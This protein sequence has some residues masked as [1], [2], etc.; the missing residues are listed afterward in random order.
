MR[1]P[2]L[3]NSLC[4][5]SIQARSKI[6]DVLKNNFACN[7]TGDIRPLGSKYDT[8]NLSIF[9][10]GAGKLNPFMPKRLKSNNTSSVS[11]P[12]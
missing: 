6:A 1:R 2:I 4:Y 8:L 9:L 7:T 11:V 5:R 12:I 10:L 3:S